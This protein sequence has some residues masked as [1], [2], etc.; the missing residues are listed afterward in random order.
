MV[1]PAADMQVA[2]K[3][4]EHQEAA[5]SNRRQLAD[6]TREFRRTS[7]AASP[8]AKAFGTLLRRC[9]LAR[10]GAG[11]AAHVGFQGLGLARP[12]CQAAD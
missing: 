7:D 6:A 5:T 8:A 9:A 1:L 12:C 11:P 3:I 4:A 2:L 10:A